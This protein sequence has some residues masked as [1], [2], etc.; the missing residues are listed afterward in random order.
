MKYGQCI[1][2][3]NVTIGRVRIPTLC[4]SQQEKGSCAH[5]QSNDVRK[6]KYREGKIKNKREEE[7]RTKKKTRDDDL[8][9]D[10]NAMAWLNA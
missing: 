1:R 10:R 3:G 2:C 9:A 5:L 8:M 6:N 7:M 4:G